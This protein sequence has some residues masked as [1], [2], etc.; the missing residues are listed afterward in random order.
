MR[1]SLRAAESL[2][3]EPEIV[4]HDDRP[5]IEPGEYLAY[6][7]RSRTYFDAHFKRWT[8]MVV[9]D[10][11]A[12][13]GVETIATV[14]WWMNLGSEKKPKAGR[15][16]DYY[17]EWIRANGAQAPARNDRMVPS[18]FTKRICRVAIADVGPAPTRKGKPAPPHVPYSVV[19]GI[20]SW[21]TGRVEVSNR[22]ASNFKEQEQQN[23][24]VRKST[25]LL[26]KEG[27]TQSQA[28][29]SVTENAW[30]DLAQEK[31]RSTRQSETR[32]EASVLAGVEGTQDNSTQGRAAEDRRPQRQYGTFSPDS[33]LVCDVAR[34]KRIAELKAQAARFVPSPATNDEQNTGS[35]DA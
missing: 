28:G 35:V 26:I 2:K 14:P 21:E 13:D 31:A 1:P 18:I 8:C 4:C 9:F 22:A 15:R 20:L 11:L 17:R 12:A 27:N 10:V 16:T 7:R 29:E 30:Q 34:A 24:R 23:Y 32:S 33:P 19:T 5:R 3:R 25:N 6:S